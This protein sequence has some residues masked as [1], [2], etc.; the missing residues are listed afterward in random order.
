M[1]TIVLMGAQPVNMSPSA[2]FET[3]GSGTGVS[4]L[5]D[6][7]CGAV[8]SGEPVSIRVPVGSD[9]W[10]E[11]LG[12][13]GRCVPARLIEITHELPWRGRLTVR[14]KQ[15]GTGR[16]QVAVTAD[17][18]DGGIN[19]IMHRRGWPTLPRRDTGTH[20]VGLLLSQSGPVAVLLTAAENMMRLAVEEINADGGIHRRPIELIAADDASDPARAAIEAEGLVRSGCRTII[21]GVTSASFAAA[22]ARVGHTRI[23]LIQAL[24]NEGGRGPSNVIRWGERPYEQVRAASKAMMATAGRRWHFIGN[25]YRW[26]WGAHAAGEHA[27]SIAGG[28]VVGST[29]VPLGTT[30]FSQ[31]IEA[32]YASGADCILSTLV[33]SDEVAFEQQAWQAGL[34]HRTQ[35]LSLAFDE[36]IRQRTGRFAAE[37]I[38]AANGYFEGLD[39]AQNRTFQRRYR[40]KHGA[41]AASGSGMSYQMYV[42]L[43]L[44]ADSARSSPADDIET[45]VRRLHRASV[46]T[47]SGVLRAVGPRYL[48][49]R[50]H[51]ARSGLEGFQLL[52]H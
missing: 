40:E 4:W 19:W 23:P 39:S 26:T 12:R 3:F 20:R 9:D 11:I 28:E 30:D 42:A 36:E 50:L 17:L 18:D 27:V 47:P 49:Q 29:R 21:A 38:W 10:V 2:L 35:T 22:C 44:Y 41:R 7:S 48:Q 8:A 46:Q 6:A 16:S 32:I 43:M 1:P 15:L 24:V 31:S 14:I 5:F 25:D 34:R 52:T 45:T 51:L 13:F 33:G 37:G